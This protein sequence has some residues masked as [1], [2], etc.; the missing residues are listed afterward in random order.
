M[1]GGILHCRRFPFTHPSTMYLNSSWVTLFLFL[2][3]SL[4]A[5]ALFSLCLSHC[6]RLFLCLRKRI[7]VSGG[8]RGG[9]TKIM[10]AAATP[11]PRA[12]APNGEGRH[13]HTHTRKNMF[14][15]EQLCLSFWPFVPS[16]SLPLLCTH[17]HTHTLTQPHIHL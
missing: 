8:R 13:T 1:F 10:W 17:T 2:I 14:G 3:L 6:S 15:Y 11:L 16:F 9:V 7:K 4:L 5:L 12:H